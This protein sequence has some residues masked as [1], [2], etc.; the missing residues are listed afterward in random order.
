MAG[1]GQLFHCTYQASCFCGTHITVF[2]LT[3]AKNKHPYQYFESLCPHR[4]SKRH[5]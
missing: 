3:L 1:L 4:V 2:I 5:R